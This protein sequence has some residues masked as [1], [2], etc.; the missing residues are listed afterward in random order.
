MKTSAP[1]KEMVENLADPTVPLG[2]NNVFDEYYL[3]RS[4]GESW[5]LIYFCPFCGERLPQSRRDQFFDEIDRLG[6]NYELG[7]DMNKLPTRYR[8]DEWW[9]DSDGRK[10]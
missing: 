1:C 9:R 10:Q 2:Y 8:T 5:Q 3:I 7:E 6:I 4:G